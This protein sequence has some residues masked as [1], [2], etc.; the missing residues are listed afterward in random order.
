MPRAIALFAISLILV[1]GIVIGQ[2][3]NFG[4]TSSSQPVIV[5]AAN[6][7]TVQRFYAAINELL[8]SGDSAALER[9]V[10]PGYVEHRPAGD[11]IHGLR[12]LEE[13]LYAMRLAFPALRMEA[14]AISGESELF[15]LAVRYA[16][17]L[18]TTLAGLEVE[19]ALP[20]ERFEIVRVREQRVVERWA[21]LPLTGSFVPLVP[22]MWIEPS[23]RPR[24]PALERVA[25][26][27]GA[28]FEFQSNHGGML[29]SESTLLRFGDPDTGSAA[30]S[31]ELGEYRVI[32]PDS[33]VHA[34]NVGRSMAS[35]LLLDIRPLAYST[36]GAGSDS[37]ESPG[38]SRTT[39][40]WALNRLPIDRAFQLQ[41][42]LATAP[43]G[44]SLP[45]HLVD[46]AEILFVIAG[47]L[48][49][50]VDG[51]GVWMRTPESTFEAAPD[52]MIV[53]AGQAIS[54]EA[55][56][57]LSYEVTGSEPAT[58]LLVTVWEVD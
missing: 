31:L 34:W 46:S 58:F 52:W 13:D 8:A 16:G 15:A 43:P 32:E 36:V 49:A 39:L 50:D 14:T 22:T 21:D 28:K 44:T 47:E 30:W 38:V 17:R 18:N 1:T 35:F 54:A 5:D 41:V 10:A 57:E 45:A 7:A 24:Q 2:L 20:A 40:A 29:V 19:L 11:E 6:P 33:R 25:L 26:Q 55:G 51:G 37:A 9:I 27:P 53:Q 4:V 23:P 56:T 48:S 3:A 42:G 12:P